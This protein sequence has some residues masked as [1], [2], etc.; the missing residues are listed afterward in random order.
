MK[1]M[2]RNAIIVPI[3]VSTH[4][5]CVRYL[6]FLPVFTIFRLEFGYFLISFLL[7]ENKNVDI[8]FSAR[9]AFLE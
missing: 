2:N 4:C 8:W 1:M 7:I 3:L 6:F 9:D 5:L